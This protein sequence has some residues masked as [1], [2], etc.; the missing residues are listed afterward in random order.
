MPTRA[1]AVGRDDIR[2]QLQKV[3]GQRLHWLREAYEQHD[4]IHTQGAWARSLGITQEMMSRIE[5]GVHTPQD[6]ILRIVYWAGATGDYVWYG[7]VDTERMLPWLCRTLLRNHGAELR[8]VKWY[9]ERERLLRET[10]LSDW[11]QL[12]PSRTGRTPQPHTKRLLLK[13]GKLV[14]A[15][16]RR[17]PEPPNND[18]A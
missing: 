2:K 14:K 18:L 16:S 4:P 8:T 3:I 15:R 1:K 7:V 13:G 9:K 11:G 12:P 10:Q 17:T 6:V 5:G